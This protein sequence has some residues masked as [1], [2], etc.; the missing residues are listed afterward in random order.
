[1]LKTEKVIKY[2][3]KGII[4]GMLTLEKRGYVYY[5]GHG[6][7]LLTTII[8]GEQ[9]GEI[10]MTTESFVK[11]LVIG[12]VAGLA[13]GILYAPKSGKEIRKQIADSTEEILNKAKMQYED[14]RKKIT[15][16]AEDKKES[17][18]ETRHA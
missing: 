12:G 4:S 7:H 15:E 1:L 14:T 16:L 3:S 13:I 2:N 8:K 17:Y 5:T 6:L 9:K 10:I 18:H 11:G